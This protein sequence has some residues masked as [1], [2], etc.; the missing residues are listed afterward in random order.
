MKL[1]KTRENIIKNYIKEIIKTEEL[2][3]EFLGYKNGIK[4]KSRTSELYGK[5][6]KCKTIEEIIAFCKEEDKQNHTEY[7]KEICKKFGIKYT[8]KINLQRSEQKDT[9]PLG[10]YMNVRYNY[11]WFS[12]Y[13]LILDSDTSPIVEQKYPLVHK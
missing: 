12:I 10:W 9:M 6:N 2:D 5:L 7:E 1:K 11:P 3:N 8:G 4:Y 13:S